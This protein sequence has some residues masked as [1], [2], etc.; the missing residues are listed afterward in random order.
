MSAGLSDDASPA[1]FNG[2]EVQLNAQHNPL[3]PPGPTDSFKIRDAG[4]FDDIGAGTFVVNTWYNVWVVVNTSTDTFQV[5]TSQGD[6]GTVGTPQIHIADPNGGGGDF[7]FVFRNSGTTLS[8]NPLTTL[9][10]ALGSTTPAL[11][12]QLLVDDVYVDTGGQNLL[13]PVPEPSSAAVL[14]AVATLGLAA[15][16]RNRRP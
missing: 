14:G 3:T 15:R 11:T 16:R 6:Y 13:N 9:A 5:W 2:Y 8:A 10:F 4:S 1:L 7:D 12:A